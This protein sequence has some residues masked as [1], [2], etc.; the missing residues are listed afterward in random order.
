MCL[1]L[2][3]IFSLFLYDSFMIQH[4][5][6]LANY[7]SRVLFTAKTKIPLSNELPYLFEPLMTDQSAKYSGAWWHMPAIPALRRLRQEKQHELK[8][9]LDYVVSSR[10]V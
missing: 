8:A 3:K 1:I 7:L 4:F 10:P 2:F 5:K 6:A 9:S